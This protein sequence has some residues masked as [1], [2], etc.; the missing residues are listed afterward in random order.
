[1]AHSEHWEKREHPTGFQEEKFKSDCESEGHP[2]APQ[3]H[4]GTWDTREHCLQTVSEY[5]CWPW[6]LHPAKIA[7]NYETKIKISLKKKFS[8]ESFLKKHLE[9][10]LHWNKR[11]NHERR[12]HIV[13]KREMFK[14]FPGWQ[15]KK[16][17][18]ESLTA[19]LENQQS[20]L[21]PE[22]RTPGGG[23]LI[24]KDGADKWPDTLYGIEN[25]TVRVLE[26][27]KNPR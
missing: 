13:K 21:D 1:M 7:I 15:S 9:N 19:S 11:V 22:E 26:G 2:Q 17:Q 27:G 12:K 3:P 8:Q 6:I 14:K 5:H 25:W 23:S 4:T 10:V 16:F 24:L 18:I 20:R